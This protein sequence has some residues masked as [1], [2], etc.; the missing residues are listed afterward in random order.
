MQLLRKYLWEKENKKQKQHLSLNFCFCFATSR[1][2]TP[3]SH[4]DMCV[5]ANPKIRKCSHPQGTRNFQEKTTN[6]L[7]H[8]GKLA[9]LVSIYAAIS[10]RKVTKVALGRCSQTFSQ[11]ETPR[12]SR[13]YSMTRINLTLGAEVVTG[14]QICCKEK[15]GS[16]SVV[17]GTVRSRFQ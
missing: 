6:C 2:A 12:K 15:R 11:S 3:K 14:N 8:G 16:S 10:V 7:K 9:K 1:P 17:T 4:G 5:A 13:A